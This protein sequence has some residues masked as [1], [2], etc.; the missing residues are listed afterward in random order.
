MTEAWA[1]AFCTFIG[2]WDLVRRYIVPIYACIICFVLG[3]IVW[4]YIEAMLS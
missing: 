1:T 2:L 4:W 3:M